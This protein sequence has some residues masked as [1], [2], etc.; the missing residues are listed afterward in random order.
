ME[1]QPTE[2]RCRRAVGAAVIGR[3]AGRDTGGRVVVEP[4][5]VERLVDR[6]QVVGV[7]LDERL[8]Q[9]AREERELRVAAEQH[10]VGE[11]AVVHQ[12]EHLGVAA[13]R[14]VV[15]GGHHR[16]VDVGDADAARH[17]L[18]AQRL[19][20]EAV[21]E[22]L[23]VHR[24]QRVEHEGRTRR[25]HPEGVAVEGDARGFVEGDPLVDA[26][27][28]GL[29]REQGVVGETRCCVARHPAA[30]VL[31]GFWHVPVEQCRD[32]ADARGQQL[33]EQAVVERYA[34][35]VGWPRAAGLDAR[36]RQ[37]EPVRVDAQLLHE[38]DVFAVAVVVVVGHR[39]I[40]PVGDAAGLGHE[41]VPRRRTSAVFAHG[42]LDLEGGGRHSHS[43][44]RGHLR[45]QARRVVQPLAA[46]VAHSPSTRV[47][48]S[49]ANRRSGSSRSRAA[50]NSS[51]RG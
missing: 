41:G 38:R 32:R 37:R 15:L 21:A 16:R 5:E 2:A 20:R 43:E 24:R 47:R 36:P 31:E 23:V 6:L 30:L 4:V 39:G 14:E 12:V 8:E 42:A 26:V 40:G 13:G 11:D 1:R 22:Q 29:R 27:T 51:K 44:A 33:V 28:E 48:Y 25:V 46:V 49:L 18:R 45:G 50:T 35:L 17:V 34:G 3:R 19:H 9:L 10:R 7:D